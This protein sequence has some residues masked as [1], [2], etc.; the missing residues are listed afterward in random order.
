MNPDDNP[1][2]AE[3]IFL[4]AS[5]PKPIVV[6]AAMRLVE[7]GKL[8][9]DDRVAEFVPEFAQKGKEEVKIRHLMTHT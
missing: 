6:A 9:L 5:V 2:T 1:V 7:Q 4:V 3:T 8:S